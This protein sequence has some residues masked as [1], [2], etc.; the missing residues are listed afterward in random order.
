MINYQSTNQ[1]KIEDF[2]T[3]FTRKLRADNRWVV[4]SQQVPWDR[5]A[6]VYMSVMSNQTG[7]AAKS[8][9]L[10]LGAL[11]IKHL[12][13]LDD[14]GTIDA[15][16][17]NPYM[18][19]FVGLEEFTTEQIFTPSLFVEIRKRVGAKHFDQLTVD[20]IKT[21]AEIKGKKS[22]SRSKKSDDDQKPRNK[23]KIKID[24]TVADQYI[25]FPTDPSLLNESREKTEMMIDQLFSLIGKQG[26]KPRTYRKKIRKEW[27]SYNKNKNKS[28]K[29]IRKIKRV[30]LEAVARNLRHIDLLLDTIQRKQGMAF[31]LPAKTQ[32]LLWVI[33]TVYD[34]QLMM[35]RKN[36]KSCP[37]RIVNIYQPHVRPIP[38]GKAKAK[39]EFGSKLGVSLDDGMARIDTFSWDAYN[40]S[41][42]L[43]KQVENYREVHGHY[44]EVVLCDRIY[45]N[46]T[47]RA[48]LSEKN[49][50]IT[51]PA[52][53]R[54]PVKTVLT[55]YRRRKLRK[56]AAQRNAIEGKFGQGKNG[57][58]LNKIRARLR[59]TSESWVACIF[60]V[61][62][63]LAMAGHLTFLYFLAMIN[64]MDQV[65]KN[66]LSQIMGF[67][68]ATVPS[69]IPM[70]E[71]KMN[72]IFAKN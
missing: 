70:N 50:R 24:A 14:R 9:R 63:L 51:A 19:Y 8:P 52:L 55:A 47:N 4:L 54:K 16:Q 45:A 41:T 48:Y 5:F 13:Y 26:V 1:L 29:Q 66:F 65:V 44:P 59:E 3:P 20:M 62:N 58:N 31:P 38:R 35:F 22:K 42:D 71:S 34:Q 7:R 57:Y 46:R 32:K 28:E 37:D 30:L 68:W 49:I 64:H 2:K 72:V 61:M 21:L 56:E 39:S 60:F 36:V 12:E 33:Q 53:G 43:I 23:G 25:P 18:Q 6:Q 15:I 11:I 40:E 67:N 10:V 27:L 69:V 17:E